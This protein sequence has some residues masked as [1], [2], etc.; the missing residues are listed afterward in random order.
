[1]SK[2]TIEP[3]KRT[4]KTEPRSKIFSAIVFASAMVMFVDWPITHV[5]FADSFARQVGFAP[6]SYTVSLVQALG[7]CGVLPVFLLAYLGFS[8]KGKWGLI[9]CLS[10]FFILFGATFF[11][12]ILTGAFPKGEVLNA[13]IHFVIAIAVPCLYSF[14][15]QRPGCRNN[16]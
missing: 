12:L 2:P 7:T 1:M 13:S 5:F 16:D 11:Y 14:L 4:S 10:S 15:V 3:A 8:P 6:G 9:L